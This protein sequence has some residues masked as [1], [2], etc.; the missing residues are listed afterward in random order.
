MK[1]KYTK[2]LFDDRARVTRKR[3]IPEESGHMAKGTAGVT[4]TFLASPVDFSRSLS[5]SLTSASNSSAEVCTSSSS[6]PSAA[7]PS[8][9]ESVSL[10]RYSD[11]RNDK[12]LLKC[13]QG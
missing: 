10:Q 7:S 13:M 3:L 11:E 12:R 9:D 1:T 8:D 6:A 2:R 5:T 4:V